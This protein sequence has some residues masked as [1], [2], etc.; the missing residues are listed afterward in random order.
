VIDGALVLT[1]EQGFS[2][3]PGAKDERLAMEDPEALD[4][5]RHLLLRLSIAPFAGAGE[6]DFEI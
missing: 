1:S 6:S 5:L 2:L 4:S 3:R